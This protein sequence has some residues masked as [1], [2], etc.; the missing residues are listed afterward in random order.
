MHIME[1]L[2]DPAQILAMGDELIHLQLTSHI[3]VDETRQLSAALDTAERA[4][5]PAAA[6]DELEG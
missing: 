5:F 6:G 4:T 1:R 3:V 2:I